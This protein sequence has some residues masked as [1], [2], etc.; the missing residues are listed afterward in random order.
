MDR[1]SD[2]KSYRWT[3]GGGVDVPRQTEVYPDSLFCMFARPTPVIRGQRLERFVTRLAAPFPPL[4]RGAEE[5]ELNVVRS[6]RT[7]ALSV[8]PRLLHGC[9]PGAR[10]NDRL[11]SILAP[12]AVEGSSDAAPLQHDPG[13]GSGHPLRAGGLH[14][15][16]ARDT[17][18]DL[19]PL[20]R[21]RTQHAVLAGVGATACR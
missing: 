3:K 17:A 18:G 9:E 7:F 11:E 2:K 20:S 1:S 21:L 10:Q 12:A 16:V 5:G 13:R 19:P 14:A 15:S 8:A 6:A 4:P